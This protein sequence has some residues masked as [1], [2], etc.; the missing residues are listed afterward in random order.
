V[1]SRYAAGV[2]ALALLV[3]SLSASSQ[4]PLIKRKPVEANYEHLAGDAPRIAGECAALLSVPPDRSA[5]IALVSSKREGGI[6]NS[7]A[8]ID[9]A[10]VNPS[11]Q[12]PRFLPAVARDYSFHSIAL[13]KLTDSDNSRV[14]TDRVLRGIATRRVLKQDATIVVAGKS[15]VDTSLLVD[16]AAPSQFVIEQ[17]TESKTFDRNMEW[18]RARQYSQNAVLFDFTPRTKEA[19]QR[20][21]VDADLKRW[22]SF[23]RKVHKSFADRKQGPSVGNRTVKALFDRLTDPSGSVV[24]L[25]AHSD[26][27]S[28]VLDTDEGV[29]TVTADAIRDLG[30]R[31]NGSLAPILLINCEARA[32]V[33]DAFLHAGSPFV[34]ASD[35]P[36]QLDEAAKFIDSYASLV[37]DSKYDVIDAFYDAH[38][39]TKPYRLSPLANIVMEA[40][41]NKAT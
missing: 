16:A 12:S 14:N 21:G 10:F 31:A 22:Q 15:D 24:V 39:D 8:Q 17:V 11:P 36:L 32:V 25:Y 29:V 7:G 34:A 19:I 26:G 30:H 4:Q 41:R 5:S 20:M 13:E 1:S 9:A 23:S 3:I 33:A 35:K 38:R 18:L 6:V 28:L 2:A 27:K 40:K 37:F